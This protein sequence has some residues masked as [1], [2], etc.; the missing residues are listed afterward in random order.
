M[1]Q[2][3]SLHFLANNR[4]SKEGESLETAFD[5]DRL[6]SA[7]REIDEDNSGTISRDELR[8]AF[9]GNVTCTEE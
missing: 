8:N 3:E 5:I 9:R 4:K 6:K 1:I 2:K 7:F